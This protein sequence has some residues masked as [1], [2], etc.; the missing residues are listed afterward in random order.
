MT[1][2]GINPGAKLFKIKVTIIG[3]NPE[4]WRRLLVPGNIRLDMLRE[5]RLPLED[6]LGWENP[7]LVIMEAKGNV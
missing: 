5:L 2:L 4:I 1:K 3:I 7:S 6:S